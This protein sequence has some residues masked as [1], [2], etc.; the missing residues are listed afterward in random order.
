MSTIGADAGAREAAAGGD[1]RHHLA[2]LRGF[3]RHDA[4]ERRAHDGVVEVALREREP[5]ARD[6]DCACSDVAARARG[7]EG[8]LRR[9][10]ALRADDGACELHFV[11]L[12]RGAR[13]GQRDF[14][15]DQIRFALLEL[16]AR[17]RDGRLGVGIVEPRDDFAAFD[18]LAFFDGDGHDLT[19]D[20]RG[21]RGLPTRDHV[22]RRVEDRGGGRGD[23]GRCELGG[24][25][26]DGDA[27]RHRD[28]PGPDARRH[29][30]GYPDAPP[31]RLTTAR[32]SI[33]RPLDT[34]LLEQ[35]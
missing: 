8:R 23:V 28:D 20:L 12:K 21:D 13:V 3:D 5:C 6:L 33:V 29:D 19:C 9:V 22:A 34:Q 30:G 7:V 25:D 1:R 35:R 11:A 31:D 15:R 24:G 14:R 17:L 27:A 4:G 2:F 16:G 32:R 18:A 10:E 26:L